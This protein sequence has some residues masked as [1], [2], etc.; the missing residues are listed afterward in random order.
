M[1]Y[2]VLTVLENLLFKNFITRNLLVEGSLKVRKSLEFSYFD[3]LRNDL[4]DNLPIKK[5]C[6]I[7]DYLR[8]NGRERHVCSYLKDFHFIIKA[9]D[10]LKPVGGKNSL[11][12][13]SFIEPKWSYIGQPQ[14]I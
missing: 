1:D 12:I 7:G 3:Q 13:K 10:Q 4:K 8:T 6:S 14:M 9:N 2:W 5:I 11:I